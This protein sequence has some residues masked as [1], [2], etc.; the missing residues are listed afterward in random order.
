MCTLR[1]ATVP[2]NGAGAVT[3]IASSYSPQGK[4]IID[5]F[6]NGTMSIS[7][8][9]HYYYSTDLQLP[10]SQEYSHVLQIIHLEASEIP[11]PLSTISGNV[12]FEMSNGNVAKGILGSISLQ[13][14]PCITDKA[15]SRYLCIANSDESCGDGYSSIS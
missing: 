2:G 8:Y 6:F 1:W 11:N 10:L 14:L 7:E 3:C 15:H 9:C 12:N 13:A 4:E 5:A